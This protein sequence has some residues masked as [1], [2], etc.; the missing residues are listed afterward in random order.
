MNGR[1]SV[2]A[3]LLSLV[4]LGAVPASDDELAGVSEP[5]VRAVHADT[6]KVEQ[7]LLAATLA[8]LRENP[9]EARSALD[10]IHRNSRAL[11]GDEV[12]VVGADVLTYDRAFHET[13]DRSR[14]LAGAGEID[15]A[16]NQ[17]VWV[18]RACRT[19][20]ALSRA[21][22]LMVVPEVR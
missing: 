10:M 18:Q 21:R 20:H 11:H 12:G 5:G 14:E 2:L 4:V 7:A 6:A 19:C 9:A 17:F 8:F 15:A 22:G 16:F 3:C 1:M 13:L